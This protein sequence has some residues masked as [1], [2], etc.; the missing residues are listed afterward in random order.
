MAKKNKTLRK[1]NDMTIV[2][3][4]VR[5]FLVVALI[6]GA[7]KSGIQKDQKK[8]RNRKACRGKVN[9]ED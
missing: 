4:P 7:T 8:E 5:D 1:S 6:N 9:V 3:G 2:P